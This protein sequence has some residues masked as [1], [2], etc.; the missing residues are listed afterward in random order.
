[1]YFAK[2]ISNLLQMKLSPFDILI[3]IILLFIL[4]PRLNNIDPY[5]HTYSDHARDYLV[6]HHIVKFGEIV[7]LG[8]HNGIFQ[9]LSSPA[10]FYFL[11][12]FLAIKDDILTLQIVNC[13]LQVINIVIL[14]F[15]A[16]KLFSQGTAFI[17]A[18]L[19]INQYMLPVIKIDFFQPYMMAPFISMTYL[20][21]LLAYRKS[22]F[23]LLLLGTVF[24]AFAGTLHNSTFGLLPIFLVISCIIIDK[25]KQRKNIF[26]YYFW[27]LM[28]LVGSITVLYLPT[29]YYFARNQT[30]I[31][32]MVIARF[33]IPPVQI[34]SNLVNNLS[35]FLNLSLFEQQVPTLISSVILFLI[36]LGGIAYLLSSKVNQYK[37]V[38]ITILILSIITSILLLSSLRVDSLQS[39]YFV[40]IFSLF[41]IIISE[42][43]NSILSWNFLLKLFKIILISSLIY[44]L[45]VN[46]RA[47]PY[48][49]Q[50]S[51]IENSSYKIISEV[52]NLKEKEN[53]NNLRFFQIKGYYNDYFVIP[54]QS[55]NIIEQKINERLVQIDSS[56][57][58]HIK[59]VNT[60]D[61]IFFVCDLKEVVNNSL[62]IC[63]QGFLRFYPEHSLLKEVYSE[64]NFF[65]Y[66][67]KKNI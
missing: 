19:L 37:K 2:I 15:F 45:I 33:A 56:A 43:V 47:L 8:P 1:M 52:N 25:L 50:F 20:F 3:I 40:P 16:K 46:I 22:S 35:Y 63:M 59:D 44:T 12:L 55:L 6:A 30:E 7:Q 11:A 29:I 48:K 65:V 51:W 31:S 18:L 9:Y 61:Y 4:L 53:R 39:Y 21:L 66:L 57:D 38:I 49:R 13:I 58:Y 5:L 24:F 10:Y 41:L 14:Y 32:E 34:F 26:R 17:T 60:N 62:E 54:Y 23:V 27:F 28:T 42:I 67:Y 36:I 64:A